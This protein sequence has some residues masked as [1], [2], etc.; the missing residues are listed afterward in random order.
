M[1]ERRLWLPFDN[2]HHGRPRCERKLRR[3]L[4]AVFPGPAKLLSARGAAYFTTAALK[5][6]YH[7]TTIIMFRVICTSNSSAARQ[8][9]FGVSIHCAM[10]QKGSH[11]FCSTVQQE[12]SDHGGPA[13]RRNAFHSLSF[14]RTCLCGP[15]GACVLER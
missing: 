4:Y 15:Y 10:L 1:I 5:Y 11:S 14:T 3:R 8:C 9:V 2:F 12:P 7:Y 13:A 6:I